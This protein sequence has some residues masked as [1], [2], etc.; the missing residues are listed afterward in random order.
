[1][2]GTVILSLYIIMHVHIYIYIFSMIIALNL[3]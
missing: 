3:I 1:M 2:L